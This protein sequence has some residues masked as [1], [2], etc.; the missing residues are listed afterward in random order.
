MI[1]VT[2]H[3]SVAVVKLN[4]G[5]TNALSL[6]CVREIAGALEDLKA[7]RAV[8]GVVITSSN[9]KFFSI[10]FDI[11]ELIDLS[12]EDF[13]VFFGTFNQM[14]L[15]L[16][17]LPKPTVAAISGHAIAGGCILAL[18]CDYR[19]IAEGRRLMGLNEIKL[20]V[21]VPFL[22][23]R[24]LR[25]IAGMRD[26]REIMETGDFYEP[27]RSLEMGMVD[28]I[29]P[30]GEVLERSIEKAR[31]LGAPPLEAYAV[32][33]R[34]R[35]E[36]IVSEFLARRGEKQEVFLNHWFSGEARRLLREAMERF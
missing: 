21:P 8:R 25:G 30:A 27:E 12:R 20:G 24:V 34:N 19:F 9:E 29:L 36:G 23:D 26:A 13:K 6:E 35:I 17:T 4:R 2:H 11:P 14:C 33:K 5:T 18:C 28:R 3:E 10:G 16:F 15:D 7:D 31:S 32:I 1:D 22:A